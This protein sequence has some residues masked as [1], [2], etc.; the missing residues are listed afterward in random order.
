MYINYLK[1]NK[2]TIVLNLIFFCIFVFTFFLYHLPIKAVIYPTLLCLLIYVG[3]TLYDFLH[4]R[5]KHNNLNFIK[6]NSLEFLE[7]LPKCENTAEQDYQNII[8]KLLENNKEMKNEFEHRYKNITEYYTVWVHQIK[9]PIASMKLSLQNEDT[10]ISRKLI[11]ELFRI[12]QYVNMVLV[13]IRLNS[14]ST[15]YLFKKCDLDSIIKQS[16]KNFSTEFIQK[17]IRLIY[18]PL[19]KTVITDEKWFAFVVEQIL[20]NSL[21]YTQKGYVKIYI[22]NNELCIE[23]SGIGIASEDLPRIFENGYTGTIGRIDKKASGLGLYLCKN[24]CDKIN[25]KIYVT[26]TINK[27][28]V[29]HIDL[30]EKNMIIE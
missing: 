27:G 26:S 15:D 12:E 7:H 2:K 19:D 29:A 9:T 6:Q 24:I 3:F 30:T 8:L 1:D 28:T 23:D 5:K 18:A 16:V 17:K 13:Y 11:S 21:K 4:Y 10:D 22:E 14:K 25:H 20:S